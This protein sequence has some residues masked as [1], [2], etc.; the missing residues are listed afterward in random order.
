MASG[1]SAFI[2]LRGVGVCTGGRVL[3]K[4]GGNETGGSGLLKRL[5]EPIGVSGS[6]GSGHEHIKVGGFGGSGVAEDSCTAG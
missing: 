4:V 3:S 5:S 6:S 1:E 2:S